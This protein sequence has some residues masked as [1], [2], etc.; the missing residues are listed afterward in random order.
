M[1]RYNFPRGVTIFEDDKGEYCLASEVNAEIAAKRDTIDA[2]ATGIAQRDAR[3]A[4]LEGQLRKYGWH[5]Y[6][7]WEYDADKPCSC[8]WAE[9]SQSLMGG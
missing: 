6:C 4:E 5:D 9:L 8:G 7:Q 3:I 2:A 1:K